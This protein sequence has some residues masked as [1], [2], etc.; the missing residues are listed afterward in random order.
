M[1]NS[2][3]T[4]ISKEEFEQAYLALIR[5]DTP[6]G[7][8]AYYEA[9]LDQDFPPH[10]RK[11]IKKLY[12][13]HA[14]GKGYL[15][16]AFR[17]SYKTTILSVIFLSYRIGLE[18]SKTNL[19]IQVKD[20]NAELT[21][22]AVAKVIATNPRF[23]YIF[24]NVGA[25]EK[26]GW[27]NKGYFVKPVKADYG[28]AEYGE[29]LAT[30]GTDPTFVGYGITSSSIIGKHPNGCLIVDDIH[31]QNNTESA[32]EL[33]KIIDILKGTVYPTMAPKITW[34]IFVGTP[35]VEGD[36]LDYSKKTGFFESDKTPLYEVVDG[37]KVYA[38]EERYGPEQEAVFRGLYGPIQ[39]ARMCMLDLSAAKGLELQEGWIGRWSSSKIDYTKKAWAGVDWASIPSTKSGSASDKR[40]YFAMVIAYELPNG[41]LVIVDGLYE[42]LTE[43]EAVARMKQKMKEHPT[44]RAIGFEALGKGESA[45]EHILMSTNLPL[46]RGG[47]GNRRKSD[48]YYNTLV[49]AFQSGKVFISTETNAFITAF[50]NEWIGYP[51]VAHDDA[52]DAVFQLVQLAIGP[53]LTAAGVAPE[54][55]AKRLAKAKAG[56]PFAH[57]NT[58]ALRRPNDSFLPK[59]PKPDTPKLIENLHPD[60]PIEVKPATLGEMFFSKPIRKNLRPSPY[61]SL[62][63]EHR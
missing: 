16:E 59:A 15:E 39:F 24:P 13:A 25:D 9:I 60:K 44:L 10:A 58:E 11:W 30:T 55:Y 42:R 35:W 28:S 47:V 62:G 49:P 53:I 50:V 45:F 27:G 18:P 51:T 63:R 23:K 41:G 57:L 36:A 46:V 56:N 6:E 19:I 21:A 3:K 14:D 22:A 12:Q 31:D 40:D 54:E 17:F 37:V 33:Q 8:E 5:S 29:W 43:A 61:S 26:R 7:F 2:P 20:E 32:A 52:L 1:E 34:I 48:R 38:W 4:P